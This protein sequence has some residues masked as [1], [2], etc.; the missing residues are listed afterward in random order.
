[1]TEGEIPPP[2]KKPLFFLK[3]ILLTKTLYWLALPG[4]AASQ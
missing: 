4:E 2:E 1:M 3:Y